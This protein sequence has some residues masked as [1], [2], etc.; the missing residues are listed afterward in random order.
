M[1]RILVKRLIS[2]EEGVSKY[3]LECALDGGAEPPE[4]DWITGSLALD[5][6]N[7]KILGYSETSE[8]WK[9]LVLLQGE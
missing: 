2:V 5:V 8:T 3:Y 6:D 1:V 4:G 7:A 9:D